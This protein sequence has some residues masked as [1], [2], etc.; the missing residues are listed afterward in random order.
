MSHAGIAQTWDWDD[1]ASAGA[2]IE[3]RLG[4]WATVAGVMPAGY[5]A[6]VCFANAADPQESAFGGLIGHAGLSRPDRLD[7]LL[8]L[9]APIT[10]D[11][12]CHFALW[13]GFGDLYDHGTDPM[14]TTSF[15]YLTASGPDEPAPDASELSSREREYRYA[16]MI[17]RPAAPTLKLPG[18][19]Y[20]LWHG[21]LAAARAM[22]RADHSPTLMWPE[23]RSWFVGSEIDYLVTILAGPTELADRAL[24]DPCWAATAT[25]ADQSPP[26]SWFE[27]TP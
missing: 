21:P 1:D 5:P 12:R 6:Y 9:L 7:Q 25:V 16:R 11:Q 27:Q 17:E 20:H 22:Q 4:T 2:W 14:R 24:A 18:R 3:A 8:D 10:G 15:G 23:D 19:A 13:T 26:P